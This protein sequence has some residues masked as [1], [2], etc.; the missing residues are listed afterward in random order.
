MR[1]STL[2]TQCAALL[3]FS[4]SPHHTKA[5]CTRVGIP[6]VRSLEDTEPAKGCT[7]EAS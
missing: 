3:P 6:L 5:G 2:E 4:A 1:N 7:G